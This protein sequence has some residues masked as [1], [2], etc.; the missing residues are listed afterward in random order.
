MDILTIN[1]DRSAALAIVDGLCNKAAMIAP[2][3]WEKLDNVR[4]YIRKS[5]IEEINRYFDED[6]H[7]NS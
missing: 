4:S 2:F 1:T 7:G 5:T 3:T 6:T